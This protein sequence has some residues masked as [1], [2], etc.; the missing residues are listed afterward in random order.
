[1]T[2]EIEQ[3]VKI[4]SGIIK[5]EEAVKSGEK[6]TPKTAEKPVQEK[7]AAENQ[8]KMAAEA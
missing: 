3:K 7:K 4:A 8:E 6:E 5:I 2:L 1:M